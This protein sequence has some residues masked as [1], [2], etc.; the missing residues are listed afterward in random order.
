MHGNVSSGLAVDNAESAGNRGEVSP[1][2]S[3][4]KKTDFANTAKI[5]QIDIDRS[6]DK[7][8]HPHT[9]FS[10]VGDV[11]EVLNA[12]MP[13]IR[14]ATRGRNGFRRLKNGER[15]T[16][17]RVAHDDKLHPF[18]IVDI[19]SRIAGEDA[20]IVTAV[21][22]AQ[23]WTAQYCRRPVPAPSSPRGDLKRWA[24]ATAPP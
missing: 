6:E 8:E 13:Q 20:I 18:Q 10:V 14:R 4:P 23:M 1:T 24:S 17:C 2:A 16:L 9:D 19:F 5:I 15:T 7:Q 21:W 3:P 11:K 12:L 22:A